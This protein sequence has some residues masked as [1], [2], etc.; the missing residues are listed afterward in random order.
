MRV[1][2]DWLHE[3]PPAPAGALVIADEQTGGRGRLGRAWLTPPGTAIALSLILRGE[4]SSQHLTLCA[5]VAVAEVLESYAPGHISL[6]WANDVLLAGKKV[7]GILAEGVWEGDRL[8]ASILGLGIN[9][10]IPAEVLAGRDFSA[11]NLADYSPSPIDRA[12]LI[13]HLVQRIEYWLHHPG[14]WAE[15]RRRLVTLGQQVTVY[16]PGRALVGLAEEVDAE[17]ALLLRL[18]DGRLERLW[19]ADVSLT[20]PVDSEGG[21]EQDQ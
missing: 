13:N 18:A 15:W 11:A 7:C 5:G 14:A 17:G 8:V 9:I 3:S 21:T 12:Q 6:K 16:A 1:A 19:A 4:K 2:R 10:A 20:A